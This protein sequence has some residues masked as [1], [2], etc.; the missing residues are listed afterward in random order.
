MVY[1]FP[2]IPPNKFR[3]THDKRILRTFIVAILEVNRCSDIHHLK[4]TN[5]HI[6][7]IQPNT[8]HY[9]LHMYNKCPGIQP[10]PTYKHPDLT[11]DHPA[12]TDI[13]AFLGPFSSS[14]R[15]S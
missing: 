14:P 6:N 9:L 5:Q 4:Q 7:T 12:I 3:E 15:P 11:P 2:L 10:T 1:L 13:K 8:E